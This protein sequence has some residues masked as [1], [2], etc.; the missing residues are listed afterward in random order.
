MMHIGVLKARKE[1]TENYLRSTL[2]CLLGEDAEL[3]RVLVA[4][5]LLWLCS[6]TVGHAGWQAQQ[7]KRWQ[8][9]AQK[10]QKRI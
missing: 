8:Q 6:L 2:A 1:R 3:G 5:W 7:S 4:D 9:T 10:A